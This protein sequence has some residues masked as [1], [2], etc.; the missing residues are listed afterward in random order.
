[1]GDVLIER[2]DFNA[3]SRGLQDP[4]QQN[5]GRLAVNDPHDGARPSQEMT[6]TVCFYSSV[7]AKWQP[8]FRTGGER[9]AR[10]DT[11]SRKTLHTEDC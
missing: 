4:A 1:M 3:P 9:W 5:A 6:T 7:V 2:M 10:L 11:G 8:G